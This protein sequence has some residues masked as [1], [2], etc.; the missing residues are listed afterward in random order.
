MGRPGDLEGPVKLIPR[1]DYE[2]CISE[3]DIPHKPK[4]LSC[5]NPN[6]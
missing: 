4:G 1:S 2:A 5:A 3:N 6:L